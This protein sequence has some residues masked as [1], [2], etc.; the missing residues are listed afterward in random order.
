MLLAL[1]NIDLWWSFTVGKLCQIITQKIDGKL[2]LAEYNPTSYYGVI[3]YIECTDCKIK[4][5]TLICDGHSLWLVLS[6]IIR[7]I[8]MK[9]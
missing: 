4:L 8:V 3:L 9:L 7:Y 1:Q 6:Y 2:I 5:Y